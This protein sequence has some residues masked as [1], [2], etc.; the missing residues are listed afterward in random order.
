ME[1]PCF[2]K[3]VFLKSQNSKRIMKRVNFEI[4]Y[5]VYKKYII[6]QFEI[7]PK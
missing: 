3:I 1:L 4:T 2:E 5:Y 6:N 7:Y